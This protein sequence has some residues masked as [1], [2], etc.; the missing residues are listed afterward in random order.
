MDIAAL[1]LS[2]DSGPAERAVAA[3]RQLPGAARAAAA[4]ADQIAGSAEREARAMTQ[5]TAS[6]NT[7]ARSA[8]VAGAAMRAAN[9]NIQRS[10]GLARH[11]MIN[12]WRQ[13]QDVFVSLRSGQ[14]PMTVLVQ[15]GTQIGDVFTSTQGTVRGFA[16]QIASMIT[17]MRLLGLGVLAISA[18]AYAA[19]S[20]WKSFALSLDDA[21]RIAG[22]TTREMAQLQAAASFKGIGQED[23]ASGIKSFST[24]LYEARSGA[25][26]L[27]TLLR[28]NKTAVGEFSQTFEGVLKL[29]SRASGDVGM[30]FS[31]LRQAG[32]PAN[33]EWVR[34]AENIQ[35]AKNE[36]GAFG[37]AANDNMVRKAREVDEAWSRFW[38]NF[39]FGARQAFVEVTRGL[40][41][42]GG[43]GS[44]YRQIV[45]YLSDKL[46]TAPARYG[47]RTKVTV[48]PRP[49]EQFGPPIPEPRPV[50]P[51]A[52]EN[53][54]RLAAESLQLEQQRLQLLGEL[55]TQ[56]EKLRLV[57]IGIE[58]ARLNPR[59]KITDDDVA[60]IR[61][62][63]REQEKL[64][65][66]RN[67]VGILGE[68]AT[69]AERYALRIGELSL[70]LHENKINQ[71]QFNRA[72]RDANP[73]FQTL[74]D[75]AVSFTQDLIAGL[76]Q[77]KSLM[78]S[79]GS[80][81]IKLGN[82]LV[83]GGI[84]QIAQGNLVT[85]GLMIGGGFLANLFGQN[86]QKKEQEQQAQQQ[87][88]QQQQQAAQEAARVAQ[89]QAD[90]AANY[91]YQARSLGIDTSSYAGAMAKLELDIQHERAEA[92]KVGGAAITAYEQLA[93]AKRY[94]LEKEWAE[95]IAQVKLSYEDRIFAA[96][97]DNAT[98][99][100]KL[101]EYD[102]KAAQERAD[103]IK[104]YGQV[105]VELEQAQA[106]E[107]GKIIKDALKEQ[108]DYY[109]GLRKTISDFTS[110]LQFG[111]LST[112]S[113]AEQFLAARNQF[114]TQYGLAIG[115]DRTAQGG[116]TGVAQTLLEQARNYLGPSVEYGSLVDRITQQLGALPDLAMAADPQVQELQRIGDS[117]MQT[118]DQLIAIS[119]QLQQTQAENRALQQQVAALIADGN[120]Q[121]TRVAELTDKLR[122]ELRQGL[123]SIKIRAA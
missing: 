122:L 82:A 9:E 123:E 44:A 57:E 78:E 38:T 18:G 112:L 13:L 108:T 66:L 88:L 29:V 42:L 32:L 4:G 30:Q 19:Y 23:F 62:Y 107:R 52:E 21:A 53:S 97:N 93:Q 54:R 118:V 49:T 12:L 116:I 26:E 45:D 121:S 73:T 110:G 46:S 117:G 104:T 33:M 41:D 58:Q 86:Q 84:N 40:S 100:G 27:Y 47:Y 102:R 113:P 99:A 114:Q 91:R 71:E 48:T 11:E 64:N 70:A 67:A 63:A 36:A 68:S 74:R 103:A 51:M 3:L 25:G 69:E 76:M 5:S 115:G 65:R 31:L 34:L 56:S 1:G 105:Y 94:A 50:D 83:S 79:L 43:E 106:A 35:K 85:G 55:T 61:E 37:G 90:A 72:V 95:K 14:S 16:S 119:Q 15:Q 87:L 39:S 120:R 7:N 2:V 109:D 6:L 22:T 101:A 10:G 80:S 60:R 20:S 92:A 59:N 75:S 111:N 81:A 98:L 28:D 24:A 77:G 8:Q 89:Q 17:P 96:T